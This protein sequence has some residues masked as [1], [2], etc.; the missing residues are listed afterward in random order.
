MQCV[1]HMVIVKINKDGNGEADSDHCEINA[2]DY[3]IPTQVY[4]NFYICT[5]KTR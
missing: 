1:E 5:I 2:R 3:F 4:S